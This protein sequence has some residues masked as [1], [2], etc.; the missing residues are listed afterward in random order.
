MKHS[1]RI[2]HKPANPTTT[3]QHR[4]PKSAIGNVDVKK[5]SFLPRWALIVIC[6]FLAFGVTLAVC[7]LFIFSKLP[8]ELLGTWV[9]Q[10]GK[11][12]GATIDFSRRGTMEAHLDGGDHTDIV[13]A[14]VAVEGNALL[15]TTP[16]PVT[17]VEKT[18]LFKIIEL[19]EARLTLQDEQGE[20]WKMIR[21][22]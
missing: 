19:T 21:P 3:R 22:N 7:E 20:L 6:V 16:H 15:V 1:T 13:Y 18:S 17:K 5:S 10:G 2:R 11:Q 8:R 9:V 14:T 12:N 4:Q